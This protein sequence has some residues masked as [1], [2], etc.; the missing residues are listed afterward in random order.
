M[1]KLETYVTLY[2]KLEQS[3]IR[4]KECL[5][6]DSQTSTRGMSDGRRRFYHTPED[7]FYELTKQKYLCSLFQFYFTLG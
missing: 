4:R 1:L 2:N 7:W 5:E 6:P 3:L